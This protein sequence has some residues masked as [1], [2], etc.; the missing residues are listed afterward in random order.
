MSV[1]ATGFTPRRSSRGDRSSNAI[2]QE[3][4]GAAGDESGT[5]AL[6]SEIGERSFSNEQSS[7]LL[8]GVAALREASEVALVLEDIRQRL[9]A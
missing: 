9:G 4:R 5:K 2:P 7:S 6:A 8:F 3:V 1:L